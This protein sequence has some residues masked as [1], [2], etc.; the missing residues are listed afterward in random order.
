MDTTNTA[1]IRDS[2][3]TGVILAGGKSSRMGFNKASAEING[4][5]MLNIMIE[6][7]CEVTPNIIVSSGSIS[8]PDIPWLQIPDEFP[9]YGPM[10]GIYSIL[11]TSTTNLNLIVS[12][13]IPL[14]S[15]SLLKYIVSEAKENGAL[16]TVPVDCTGQ[17][18][19]LCAVYHKDILSI[20]KQQIESN[21]L[22]MKSLLYLVTVGY[23]NISK[24]HPI[25]NEYDFINVNT[26]S[27]LKIAQE[28]WNNK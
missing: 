7:L 15:V 2:I 19:M 5:T 25:Y 23:I 16:I 28:L 27:T 20:L 6:K 26:I 24:E 21:Q 14:V 4:E 22:K 1:T 3:I 12:C 18:Q 17:P 10:G 8:Y 9:Q 11:K 13:D